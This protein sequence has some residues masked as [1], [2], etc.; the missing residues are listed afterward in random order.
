MG[1]LIS[2][3]LVWFDP[4]LVFLLSAVCFPGSETSGL[5]GVTGWVG[6]GS[7]SMQRSV[8]QRT[9][10]TRHVSP[11]CAMQSKGPSSVLSETCP[12]TFRTKSRTLWLAYRALEERGSSET[13]P[14]SVLSLCSDSGSPAY[15]AASKGKDTSKDT[16]FR[17]TEHKS[18]LTLNLSFP[19]KG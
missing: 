2:S 3:A 15:R 18:E 8:L 5:H 17:V 19:V 7:T 1:D 10:T 6:R 14:G 16:A 12:E 9:M 13:Q 11:A 4:L